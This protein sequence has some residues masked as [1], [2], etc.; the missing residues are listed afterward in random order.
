MK[1]HLSTLDL[2]VCN[3]ATALLRCSFANLFFCPKETDW[4]W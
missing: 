4:V 2:F 3:A 1:S